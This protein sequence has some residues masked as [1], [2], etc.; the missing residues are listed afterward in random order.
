[1]LAFQTDTAASLTLAGVAVTPEPTET[2][3]GQ[4][5]S[6]RSILTENPHRD[7]HAGGDQGAIEYA[8][9][10]FDRATIESLAIRWCSCLNRLR[11]TRCSRSTGFRPADAA[12]GTQILVDWNNT[13][14]PQSAT[15]VPALFAAQ[16]LRTPGGHGAGIRRRVPGYPQLSISRA[17]Q[18]AHHLHQ[19]RYRTGK[20]GCP[21]TAALPGPGGPLLGILKAGAAYLP[22]DPGYPA[23]AARIHAR[24]CA[25]GC[26][27]HNCRTCGSP[28][29]RRAHPV[30]GVRCPSTRAALEA[31]RTATP[32]TRSAFGR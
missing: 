15:T 30:S 17:N 14:R 7:R 5:R 12:G 10:L 9:D 16:V 11:P 3:G 24:G 28:A 27:D 20:P 8:T 21:G 4:I 19:P 31:A 23:R 2:G 29:W 26:A 6:P 18:L 1:M 32:R 22:L 13:A 25:P